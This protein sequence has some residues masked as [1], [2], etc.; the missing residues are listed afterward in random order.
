MSAGER[1][2]IGLSGGVDS[3]VAAHLLLEQGL[4]VEALFMK[5]WEEDDGPGYCAA[6]ED[7]EDAEAVAQRLG[8]P[9]HRVNFAAE[10]WD[11]VFESFLAE[12]RALTHP[13]PR[14]PL[15]PRD[16]VPG[17]PGP[18]PRARSERHRDRTLCP[19]HP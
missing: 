4:Q 13:E 15:Q 14:R 19:G 17:L 12:Y 2:M 18:C 6:A 3:A 16:Q 9:L 1:V 10:Y 7:L 5:N 8:I 11:R